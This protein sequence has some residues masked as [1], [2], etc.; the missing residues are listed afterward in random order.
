MALTKR[1]YVDQ[2]TVITAKNLNDIQDEIIANAS[3]IG[4][5][6]DKV[7]GKGLSTEDYTS[8]EKSKLGGIAEGAEVNVQP[9]WDQTNTGADDYIK[10]KPTIPAAQVNSDWNAASGVAQIL[11]KPTLGTAAAKNVGLANGVA[12]LDSTGKVPSSQLPAYVDDVLEYDSISDFPSTGETGK[13]YVAKDTNK[14][15]RWGGSSYVEISESLAL[16]ETSSTAYRGDRGKTA[17]DDSQTNKANIGTMANLTTAE[18]GSL[19]GAINELDADKVDAE[20]GKGLSTNDFTNAYKG[21]LDG[22]QVASIAET[23]SYLGIT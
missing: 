11:N 8:S 6:V 10:N 16:G 17:Y 14:T 2:E 13:I 19:V 20:Q 22:Y 3:A 1:T 18:K 23:K 9:D 12:E 21:Q 5:K 4:G 7:Q 15:Y